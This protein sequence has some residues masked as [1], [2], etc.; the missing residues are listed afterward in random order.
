M[1]KTYKR[2]GNQII[3]TETVRTMQSGFIVDKPIETVFDG[4]QEIPYPVRADLYRQGI[5]YENLSPESAELRTIRSE[6][7]ANGNKV[8]ELE[9]KIADMKANV[10]EVQRSAEEQ[11]LIEQVDKSIA[12]AMQ[13]RTLPNNND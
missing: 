8:A 2:V 4:S 13:G 10:T 9:K 11:K 6:A 5:S 1:S 12:K 3:M 7:E